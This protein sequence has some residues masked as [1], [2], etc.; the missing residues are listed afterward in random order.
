MIKDEGLDTVDEDSVTIQELMD[1]WEIEISENLQDFD[2]FVSEKAE[3]VTEAA[4][5]WS[6][7]IFNSELQEPR[8]LN[9]DEGKREK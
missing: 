1:K 8:A 9:N 2:S 6:D 5:E 7:E 3:Q 4:K